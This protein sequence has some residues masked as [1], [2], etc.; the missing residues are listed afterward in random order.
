MKQKL[1]FSLLTALCCTLPAAVPTVS[2]EGNLQIGKLELNWTT[3]ASDWS[4][5][6]LKSSTFQGE[7]NYPRFSAGQFE[8]AGKWN[9]FNLHVASSATADTLQYSARFKA[10][11]PVESRTLALVMNLPA[12]TPSPGV[13]VDG[14]AVHLPKVFERIQLFGS[15][16]IRTLQ[17]DLDGKT[18]TVSGNYTLLIQDDRK[19][20]N[21]YFV[22][23]FSA[24]P[25]SGK[26]KEASL[27]LTIRLSSPSALPVNLKDVVN[28]GFRDPKLNDGKGGWTDQGP[29]NDLY[30]M[31]PGKLHALG[32]EFQI[33][34]PGRNSGRSC[35]VLSNE[36][37][38][39]PSGRSVKIGKADSSLRYLYL[40]H[41]S[42]WTPP[43]GQKVG[44]ILAESADGHRKEYPVLA[45]RDVGNWWQPFHFENGALAWTGEN[46][47]SY[48][49]LYLSCF[50][51]DTVP[52]KLT[53]RSA[54][55]KSGV[56]MI[57]A[58]TLGDRKLNLNQIDPPS[59]L[60]A[61][62]D[63]KAIEFDG[64]TTRGSALDFSRFLDAPAGKYGPVV[65]GKNGHFVFRDA[66][67]KRIRFF[68]PNLVGN[69]SYLDKKTADDFVEKVTRLG[70]NSIRFH[71]FENDLLDPKAADSLTFHPKALDQFDYLFAELKKRGIYLCLDL[72]AS[73]ALRPGDGIKEREGKTFA[74]YDF[75]MKS[76]VALS[77]SAMKNWKEF[78]RRLLTHRNPY[79][80]LTYAE[81]PAL[82]SLN[83]VNENPL[84]SIWNRVPA[85]IPLFEAKYVDFLKKRGLDTPANRAS[86]GGLFMEFLN[87]LQIR[88]IRE[89]KRFLK[90]ELKLTALITDLN[91]HSRF[92]LNEVREHLDF[93]DNHQYWDHPSFPVRQWGMP[94]LFSNM[95]SISR[96][97]QN[98][99]VLMPARIFG[100]PYTVTEFNFC[101]PNPYRMEAPSLIG[102]YAGLQDWDG[103]YRFAWSH[104]RFNM[105]KINVPMGFDI[106][107]D[108]Q[109]QLAERIIHL[110]FLQEYIRPAKPGFAFTCTPAELRA[111]TGPPESDGNFPEDFTLL[112]LYGRIGSL[113]GNSS[114]PGVLRLTPLKDGWQTQLP[115]QVQSVLK[116]AEETGTI[117]SS[118]GELSLNTKDKSLKIL[119]PKCEVFTFSGN[120]AG[121][122]MRITNGSRYQTIALLSLD[123]KTLRE[124]RQMLLIQLPNQGATKMKFAN[125][126][127]N[128]LESWGQLPLQLEKCTADVSLDLT[129]NVEVTAL[130][131]NGLPNGRIPLKRINGELRFKLDSFAR[132]GCVMAYLLTR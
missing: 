128:L 125:A 50:A 61:G 58:A 32:M 10:D 78:A 54:E 34:D 110:L 65:V 129:G 45:S 23:R 51:L 7:T 71:H 46:K 86:R 82:Y 80:G 2:K 4:A 44:T 52:E 20:R 22:F 6:T 73:R 107:N 12:D 121:N 89:Q 112:G 126:R 59:Y 29:S 17:L 91:M 83:L 117:T 75:E 57:V 70:Y 99:R 130:K 113:N 47:E 94:Y 102:G 36:Q 48:V 120:A 24:H 9:G 77:P 18:I 49:G 111:L 104:N 108:P 33:L 72:Y 98:P 25:G 103:L 92:P 69:S 56:W 43:A 27:D 84:L 116:R 64:M 38:K 119:A 66:P 124:S 26:L 60:V 95:S 88:C 11:P 30:M 132:K 5:T 100:K 114:W 118:G 63:W 16:K 87:D 3:Y 123:G 67:E 68:G 105:E 41:A 90:Q 97:A 79:T 31:K 21:N 42:A 28:M 1:I 76:L 15:R 81:D 93:V 19:W 8:T 55:G 101:S 53:F 122:V 109:A 62:D 13:L 74:R 85:L 40:L 115:E 106:V 96:F 131:N 35:L 14:K 39:F 127:R 37:K